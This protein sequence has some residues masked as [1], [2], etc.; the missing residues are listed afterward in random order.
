MI[1]NCS[2]IWSLV[3][4][5]GVLAGLMILMFYS[6]V[7]GWTLAYTIKAVSGSF[8]GQDAATLGSQFGAFIGNPLVTGSWHTL[9]MALTV[10]LVLLALL[11]VLV[12]V[13]PRIAQAEP[14]DPTPRVTATIDPDADAGP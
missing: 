6:V 2:L 4:I 7:A 1:S 13:A 10:V 11:L 14:P 12:G 5:L 8:S 9:F 3:G